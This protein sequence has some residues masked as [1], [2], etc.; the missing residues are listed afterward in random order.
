MAKYVDSILRGAKPG[1]L[2]IEQATRVELA[3]NRR[4]ARELGVRVPQ[5][6]LVR[7]DRTIE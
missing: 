2:P 1:D 3:L 5:T 6:V 7:A 4:T